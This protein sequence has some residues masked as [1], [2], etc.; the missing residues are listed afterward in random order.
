MHQ[1]SREETSNNER[2]I[3][4]GCESAPSTLWRQQNA[5]NNL[6]MQLDTI[7]KCLLLYEWARRFISLAEG[8]PNNCYSFQVVYFH[9]NRIK[10]I[11][12]YRRC[13][14][15][16]T[17]SPYIYFLILNHF[18]GSMK[19]V[20]ENSLHFQQGDALNRVRWTNKFAYLSKFLVHINKSWKNSAALS[21]HS[22]VDAF[23]W[24]KHTSW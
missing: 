18:F 23:V 20:G 13:Y 14:V 3:C 6:V 17:F 24:R 16:V 11:S 21:K 19:I 7:S 4:F 15:Y 8:F 5:T 22:S 10:S 1:A 12:F 2:D 9:S